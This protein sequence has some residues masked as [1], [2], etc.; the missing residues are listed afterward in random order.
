[1]L[2]T[3]VRLLMG[4]ITI[5]KITD[6]TI[7]TPQNHSSLFQCVKIGLSCQYSFRL[8]QTVTIFCD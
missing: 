3:N 6:S 4:S 1:M 2:T 8:L 7:S 5:G